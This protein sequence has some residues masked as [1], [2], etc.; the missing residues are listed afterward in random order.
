MNR[1]RNSIIIA[2]Y[3]LLVGVFFCGGY[4]IGSMQETS[5]KMTENVTKPV[6]AVN[7]VQEETVYKLSLENGRLS[8]YKVSEGINELMAYEDISTDI[9]PQEDIR[10]LEGGVVFDN[11]EEA[12][13]LFENF[14]S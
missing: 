2:A 9:Y 3:V 13:M 4:A 11:I 12:Q 6:A 5:S 10:E 7:P 8:L 14:V 1:I